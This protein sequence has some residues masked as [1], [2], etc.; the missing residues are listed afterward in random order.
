MATVA[1]TA[2]EDVTKALATAQAASE[3]QSTE[4]KQTPT[5]GEGDPGENPNSFVQED[6]A[7]AALVAEQAKLDAEAAGKVEGKA[8]EGETAGATGEVKEGDAEAAAAA[9]VKTDADA[10]AAAAAASTDPQL[11]TIIALRKQNTDLK[12]AYLVKEGENRALKSLVDPAKA[13]GVTDGGEPAGETPSPTDEAHTAIEA[14]R[15]ALAA[16][17]DG[18][19]MSMVEYTK[20]V[21]VLARKERELVL[22]EAEAMA[23]A[24]AASVTPATDLALEEST[25]ALIAEYP[26]LSKL[27][28]AQLD[29]INALAYQQLE[30][31][32]KPITSESPTETKRLRERMADLAEQLYDAPAHE[33]RKTKSAT[34][35]A[36]V[37]AKPGAGNVRVLPTA[38]QRAA[39]LDLAAAMPPEVGKV[40]AGAPAGELT[41]E[42]IAAALSGNE[43]QRIAFMESHPQLI[44]KVMGPGYRARRQPN[45]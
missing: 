40:G 41:E 12:A 33:V 23:Q 16:K 30:L 36:A 35:A 43:D 7:L 45:Q 18:G 21:N 38:E 42:Q 8:K 2:A 4:G 19:T 14:E 25:N 11:R 27:T 26:V 9:K 39:K 10:A 20:Q 24:A 44:A 1:T 22:A 5:P 37:P 28:R 13:A 15:E 6:A 3:A 32:G 34:A 29:P 17:V 31:E